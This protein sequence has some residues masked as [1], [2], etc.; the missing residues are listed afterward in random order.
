MAGRPSGVTIRDWAPRAPVLFSGE[1]IVRKAFLAEETPR[2]TSASSVNRIASGLASSVQDFFV[3]NPGPSAASYRGAPLC[4]LVIFQVDGAALTF[5]YSQ[6]NVSR[7]GR[8]SA[9]NPIVRA[10]Q[11]DEPRDFAHFG[12]VEDVPIQV[13]NG[14]A[15]QYMPPRALD[16]LIVPRLVRDLRVKDGWFLASSI[17][18]AIEHTTAGV[19]GPIRGYL[20]TATSLSSLPE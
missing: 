17:I 16:L 12:E 1:D 3:R 13:L 20:I 6:I 2:L 4:T 14:A 8:V 19:G 10:I 9:A 11:Q 5:G 7:D 15:R 18:A